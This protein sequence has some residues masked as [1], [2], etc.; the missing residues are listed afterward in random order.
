MNRGRLAKYS[1]WQFRDFVLERGIAIVLIGFLWGYVTFEPMR[2]MLGPQWTGDQRSPIWGLAIQFSSAVVSLSVLI[3]MNGITSGDRKNGYYRFL[4]SKPVSPVA[5]YAQL[6]CVYLVG[7]L[8]AMLILSGLLHIILPAFSILYFLV[9]VL[10]IYVGMGGIGF[11][12]SVATRYD[13]VTLAAVW[14]GARILRAVYGIKNDWRSKAVELL[15][16]VH[17]V[18]DVA[19]SLIGNGTAHTSDVVWLLGYGLLFFVLGLVFLWRGSLAD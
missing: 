17:R 10:L 18:D 5:Y 1:L 3:A 4:F 13:W 12:L 8:L 14:L 15:P 9:Y 6:F 7:V 16:P 19:N 2:K 11:F